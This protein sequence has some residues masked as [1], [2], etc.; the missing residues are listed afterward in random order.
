MRNILT[1][2]GLA[3]LSLPMAG[4]KLTIQQI[5]AIKYPSGWQWTADGQ[6]VTFNWDD[7]GVTRR[8]QVSAEQPAAPELVPESGRG[9]GRGFGG[10][11]GGQLSPDG[12]LRL[13]SRGGETVSHDTSFPEIGN[14]VE[15]RIS[16]RT[17]G[18]L[19]AVPVAGGPEVAIQEPPG[20][21][22]GARWVSGTTLVASQVSDDAKTRTI[23]LLDAGGGAPR[24]VYTDREAKFFSMNG[25]DAAP[26]VSPD[27][28]WIFFGSDASGWDQ[29]YVMPADGSAAVAVTHFR[30]AA[31]RAAWSHDSTR[32]AFDANTLERPGD[33][34]IGIVALNGDPAQA[35]MT[36]LTHGEGTN[37]GPVWSPDDTRIAY[38][39]ADA[40]NSGDIYTTAAA[41][42]APLRLTHSMPSTMR[43]DF[44]APTLI[45]YP[46]AD[47]Q[48]VPAWLFV[49]PRLD[50]GKKHAAI[51]W[52]HPD[53]VNQNYDGWHTDRNEA[54]YYAFHQYL[55]QEGYVVIAP[56]Y[57][58]S[59]GYGSAWRQ[60]V[61]H[62]VGGQDAKDARLAASYLKT[63]PYVDPA[64]IGVWG[65]S[66][67]GYF[68]L[69]AITREPTLFA[70]AVDMAGL[71][72]PAMYYQD[73]YHS[74][75]MAERMGTPSEN[76]ELYASRATSTHMGALQRP[77]LVLAGTADVNVPFWE[78]TLLLDAALKAGKGDLIQFMMYP[79]EFHYFDRGFVLND[80][81]RRVDEFFGAQL[82]PGR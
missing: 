76:P 56:D 30:G 12:K 42:G 46:A 36:W 75:W 22:G 47:G 19:Y 72:D 49:P 67:G 31:W 8:Y 68:T 55:L 5:V 52:I 44:V 23:Y 3:A 74:G 64:R 4:Q 54:V 73:P 11:G 61:W 17:A 82:K 59:I 9:G 63:L 50:R 79:G 14:K 71:V 18:K 58:G 25:R 66:Y 28:K 65:L 33:R 26:Q 13:V 48:S 80:A 53:G 29:L 37:I 40:Q 1:A 6:N 51:V 45:H 60:A 10:R 77:L 21:V 81:W 78:T 24:A 39:H 2:L 7:A 43:P 20:G 34:Q 15:F 32:I 62:D 70:C 35:S 38:Q 57:R 16:E 41:G 27:R 69:T